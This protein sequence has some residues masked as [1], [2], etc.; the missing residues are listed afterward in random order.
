[1]DVVIVPDQDEPGRK[2]AEQVARALHLIARRIRVFNLPSPL[3]DLSEWPLSTEALREIIDQCPDWKPDAGSQAGLRLT[4]LCDL[5]LE[6]EEQL[7]WT[8]EDKLPAGGLSVL[9]AKPKVGKST[10]ARGLCLAVARGQAFMN[11][12]TK[13][14]PVIYLAL[15]E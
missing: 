6:P 5:L 7:S 13:K 2:H 15:E 4:P 9:C 14:G 3:K 12:A 11:C 10:W 1:K 8:L